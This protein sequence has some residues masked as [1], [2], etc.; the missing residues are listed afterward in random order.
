MNILQSLMPPKQD[1]MHDFRSIQNRYL[2]LIG[3]GELDE[4]K[5]DT[6]V[7]SASRRIIE[8]AEPYYT[9]KSRPKSFLGLTREHL[10]EPIRR[11]LDRNEVPVTKKFSEL[12]LGFPNV[13]VVLNFLDSLKALPHPGARPQDYPHWSKKEPWLP[14]E[15]SMTIDCLI[16]VLE[17]MTWN[18]S[19][20]VKVVQTTPNPQVHG[21][22][23]AVERVGAGRLPKSRSASEHASVPNHLRIQLSQL[24]KHDMCIA[25]GKPV[26]AEAKRSKLLKQVVDLE[27]LVLLKE[28]AP[29]SGGAGRSVDYCYDHTKSGGGV[30]GKRQGTRQRLLF[31]SLLAVTERKE[32]RS[33]LFSFLNP[34]NMILFACE[35]IRNGACRRKLKFVEI[36]LVKLVD[37]STEAEDAEKIGKRIALAIQSAWLVTLRQKPE[38]FQPPD[39]WTDSNNVF[40]VQDLSLFLNEWPSSSTH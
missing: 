9:I 29:I 7:L 6:A 11:W 2:S 25:C 13:P 37:H 26:A 35:A 33:K 31:L 4:T 20:S 3:D 40:A 19:K 5:G 12:L 34:S 15:Y 30:S 23:E 16:E 14:D 8:A 32:V 17:F 24:R 21:P 28:G 1:K 39:S 38:P 18:K 22:L 27:T 36:D 10:D